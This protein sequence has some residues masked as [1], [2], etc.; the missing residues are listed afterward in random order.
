MRL[1]FHKKLILFVI[2]LSGVALPVAA[3]Q[4]DP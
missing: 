1:S 2:I 4:Y 3:Q